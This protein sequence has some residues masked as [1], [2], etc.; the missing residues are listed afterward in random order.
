MIS[1]VLVTVYVFSLFIQGFCVPVNE[2]GLKG[3]YSQNRLCSQVEQVVAVKH[4]AAVV[5]THGCYISR[6]GVTS[7]VE[8]VPG[9]KHFINNMGLKMGKRS[10]HLV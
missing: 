10:I 9:M 5:N 8:Y 6:R 1:Y 2:Y 3:L 7:I 4:V